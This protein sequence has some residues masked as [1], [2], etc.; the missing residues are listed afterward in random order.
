VV[1]DL[2]FNPVV[3]DTKAL[4]VYGLDISDVYVD[5]HD[6]A[7]KT[8]Y[9]TVAGMSS[10]KQV[11][12]T[13]YRSTDGGAHWT[14]V[15]ANLPDAP[16][17]SVIAD[18][19]NA[20]TVYLATDRGVYFTANI[21]GCAQAASN[22][23]SPF[24]A[25]LPGAPVV[26][27]NTVA[28]ST[29][30]LV[31]GTYGR[32]V[33][34]TP[35]WSASAG[36]T[37]AAA[38]PPSLT[39]GSET[40]G[41]ASATQTV[42]LSNTGGVALTV[43]SV[44][45]SG[46]FTE[47]DNCVNAAV[48]AGGSCA[49]QVAF[50]P[51]AAGTQ[52][53]Q[54]AIAGNLTG[55]P[56][57]VDLDGTGTAAAVVTVTPSVVD[58][59]PVGVGST[60]ASLPVSVTNAGSAAVPI[61]SVAV[62]GPF[63]IASNACGTTSLPANSAC[64]IDVEFEPTQAGPETGALVLTDAAGTQ[65]VE[66]TGVGLAAAT[67]TLS[68]ASLTFPATAT[69][70]LS[71]AQNVTI[72]NTG[73]QTLTSIAASVSSGFTITN[74]CGTQLAANASC[75]IGVQF[76]PAQQ[77]NIGGTLTITDVL[78]QQTVSLMGMGVAPAA[79]GVNP[80]SFTF[81]NQQPGVA[82]QPQ[83]LTVTNIGGVPMA[84]VGFQITGP[85]A[86]SYS[87]QSTTCGAVLN[88]GVSCMA[89]IVFTPTGTGAIAATL[90]VSSSTT[91][92]AA[93][94]VLLNGAGQLASGL[95]T[96]PSQLGFAAVVGVGQSS[97][98]QMVTVT[99]SS[100]YSIASVAIAVTAPFQLAQNNCTS[101]LAA[102][103]NCNAAVVFA[104]TAAG[105]ATGTMTISSAAVATPAT[106]PLAG[107]GFDFALSVSG[108]ASVT[109]SSGQT[110]HFALVITP[111]GSQG[112]FAFACGSAPANAACTFNPPSETLSAGVQGNVTVQ[113]ATGQSNAAA[114]GD[115]GLRWRAVPLVCGVILL[116]FALARRRRVL[117]LAVLAM[118]LAAGA[119]SCTSSSGGTGGGPPGEG[120][121]GST[122][123]G[124]Y[125]IPVTISSTGVSHAVN[126]TL[127]VD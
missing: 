107:T 96:N 49:I 64:A 90:V 57:A 4:N 103:A 74:G 80:G 40:V 41:T 109:V 116:P 125:T 68:M 82:S 8:V 120:N 27:L 16:A 87:I 79:I 72:T 1:T 46:A 59:G 9:V 10:L 15:T 119:S 76:A 14:A 123:A 65:S 17:N 37:T 3:N 5:P 113:I 24:G 95:G 78:R 75:S 104:P 70:Q 56:V 51:A 31:A 42:T 77:G 45:V 61:T 115:S 58:F 73:G 35:L 83:T 93:V 55:G 85:A 99:N 118:I 63:A 36:L 30:A 20:N 94:Q 110:A 29:P 6:A 50:A 38:S 22:C 28:G 62:T 98:A 117:L 60:S 112:A 86:A 11:V 106:V 18:P 81:T 127:V 100:S 67:D 12:Q 19:Q 89:Q 111:N 69:G 114:R 47:V 92:V 44:A 101:T 7:G 39:F 126:V 88:N 43:T 32:G 48:P 105:A 71:A 91:G 66:L 97:A 84:N 23:W 2:T 34:Q 25:G 53:G 108:P 124:T 13:V 33:W 121:S 52:T 21:G 26:V 122:P 102:G 54:L